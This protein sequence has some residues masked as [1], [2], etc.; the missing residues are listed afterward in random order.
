[1]DNKI[2]DAITIQHTAA[3]DIEAG[4]LVNLGNN[5][6]GVAIDDIANGAVGAVEIRGR[7][8]VP[9][10]ETAAMA[11]GKLLKLGTAGNTVKLATAGTTVASV[12]NA[13]VAKAATTA[14]TTV[15]III[16]L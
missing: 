5:F 6:C 13:R 8:T 3:A 11:I 12:I 1:M 16:G 14:D 15:E 7:F 4:D 2:N 10:G 9:K